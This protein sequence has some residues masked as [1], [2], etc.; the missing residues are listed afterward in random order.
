MI[1]EAPYRTMGRFS[2]CRELV[3]SW[4]IVTAH[5]KGSFLTSTLLLA[6]AAAACGGTAPAS[7]APASAAAASSAAAKPV[8]S[9]SAQAAAPTSAAAPADWDATVAAAKKEGS[10]AVF[11]PDGTDMHDVLTAPFEK[12]FG[13]QVDYVG[14]PGP[15]I[16]PRITTER[17]AGKYQWDIVVA[18]TSTGLAALIPAKVLDPMDQYLILQIGRA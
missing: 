5:M 6:L 3:S 18:G 1:R 7:T 9:A 8:S 12:Q 15:G 2:Y 16:P 4:H 14:D 17:S 11:G 10:V 13:I